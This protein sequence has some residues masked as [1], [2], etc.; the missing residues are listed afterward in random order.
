MLATDAA[1]WLPDDLNPKVDVA[2]MAVALEC[3]APLQDHRLVELCARFPARTHVRRGVRK[4]LLREALGDRLPAA[5]RSGPKR[6]FAAPVERWFTGDLAG[7]FAARLKG[8]ALAALEVVRP[9]GVDEVIARLTRGAP[10]GRPRI[11]AF[12][13]LA[14]AL[15]AERVA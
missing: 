11:G 5:V 7:F 2:S 14:L 15:W 3:R 8:P 12:V 13:L 4:A 9:E 10:T 6:G 1:T